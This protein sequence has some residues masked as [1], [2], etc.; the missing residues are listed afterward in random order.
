MSDRH[1]QLDARA[2]GLMV[3]LCATWGLGQVAAKVGDGSISPLLQGGLRSIGAT[4]LLW[5]WCRLRGVRLFAR[6]GSL[7]PG[8]GTGLL[9]AAEFG[10]FY[11]GIVYTPASHGVL[12]L[13]TAPFMVA[14]GLHLLVP[15]ERLRLPQ[16][17]GLLCAFAGVGV[18]FAEGLREADRREWI[19][20]VMMLG[21]AALWAAT[22]ILIRASALARIDASKTLFYQLAVSAV[23]LTLVSPAVGEPGF[24]DP[25]ALG[26]VALA[27]QVIV[28][29]S[30]SYLAWF[31][32]VRHYPATQLSAFTFLTPLFAMAFGVLL[33][34]EAI[35]LQL[36]IAFLLVAA[37]LWLV[38]RRSRADV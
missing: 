4:L 11:W 13:Y 37:G 29:A 14:I 31:W 3:L 38:N 10:M 22:T 28:V 7:W 24:T 16:F 36:V 17:A 33:L 25:T 18:A 30:A 35:T 8:L 15:A 21:A 20:D 19:G 5:V 34:H 26:I 32:L 23:A 9:F 2:M 6:D 12:F 1:A 27:W